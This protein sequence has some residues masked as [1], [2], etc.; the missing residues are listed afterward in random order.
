[1]E[2]KTPLAEMLAQP[3]TGLMAGKRGLVMGVAND[4]S[5]AW[6]ISQV[7]AS[8]GAEIAFTYQG[9]AQKK[10]LGPLAQSIGSKILLPADVEHDDQ[11][12]AVFAMLAKE[13]GSL[14]F[15]VH[16]LAFSDAKELKGRYVDTSRANFLKSLD[17]SC[18]SFTAVAQRAARLMGPNG[19][20]MVTLSYLGAQRVM[21][22]YNV[23]GVAK[24]A[25]EASVRYLAS[26]LGQDGI[27]VNAIS[28]GPM[29]TLAGSAVGDARMVFKWNKHNSPLKRSVELN[30]VGG[31][32]L[33]LLSDLSGGVTGEIHFVDAG[34]NVVGMPP[35]ADLKG[36]TPPEKEQEQNNGSSPQG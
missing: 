6:G 5:I 31:A 32:A 7:L 33:Y 11:L 34:F 23:M 24:A 3:G 9:D 26:D 19:G 28:A 10:R 21:P 35:T 18:F 17:I 4:H 15:V 25:L 20:A 1:M 14:D 27:R 29:R 36:W 16:S 30:H 22:N 8:Q 2:Q 13:W 12:D